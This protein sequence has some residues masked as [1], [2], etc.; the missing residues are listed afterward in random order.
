MPQ[1]T[2]PRQN[3]S[4]NRRM[5]WK[6]SDLAKLSSSATSRL[7]RKHFDPKFYMSTYPKVAGSGLDP[8][9]HYLAKGWLEGFNPCPHFDTLYYRAANPDVEKAGINPFV[10]YLLHGREEGRAS[11]PA[12][13]RD[14]S[15]ALD[16]FVIA[17]EFDVSYY[18]SEYP[19]V[20]IANVDPIKTFITSG[21]KEA[22]R[23]RADFHTTY[24]YFMN[25]DVIPGGVNPFRHYIETGRQQGRSPCRQS[26]REPHL[27]LIYTPSLTTTGGAVPSLRP[28]NE[29]DYCMEVPFQIELRAPPVGRIA[30]IIHMYYTN[31]LPKIVEYLKNIP[32]QT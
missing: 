27:R 28:V 11:Q 21:W 20:K 25:R 24:Y 2:Y 4:T 18:L 23:P 32:F 5:L 31:V 19:D 9:E 6:L 7:L 26:G 17:P 29:N 8:I 22:R 1:F 13:E 15:L 16:Y 12:D 14:R 3:T 10:H 30:A